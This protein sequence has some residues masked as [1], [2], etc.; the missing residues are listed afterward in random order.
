MRVT[1]EKQFLFGGFEEQDD[2]GVIHCLV[3]NSDQAQKLFGS[4]PA[5]LPD[6][7]AGIRWREILEDLCTRE[8]AIRSII[9]ATI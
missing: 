8:K 4:D 1:G 6:K 3:K 2:A 7:P 5:N 9:A